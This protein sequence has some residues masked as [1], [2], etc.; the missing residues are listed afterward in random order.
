M[1][2]SFSILA[3]VAALSFAGCKKGSSAPACPGSFDGLKGTGAQTCSCSGD[4]KQSGAVWGTDIYTSDSSICSAAKHDGMSGDVTVQDAPGCDT[5]VGSAKNGVTTADWGSH[6]KSFY[7]TSHAK[8][9]C[10][11][12]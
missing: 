10:P 5:Y 1:K 9:A 2:I 7:F 3:A 11:G 8:P 12:K 4:S 6:G